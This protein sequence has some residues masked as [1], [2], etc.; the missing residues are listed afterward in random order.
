MSEAERQLIGGRNK[1]VRHPEAADKAPVKS[2]SRPSSGVAAANPDRVT[3]QSTGHWD[4]LCQALI[5]SSQQSTTLVRPSPSS[6]VAD[7]TSAM[8]GPRCA[9]LADAAT[10]PP[11]CVIAK[12]VT[13]RI[14]N[15][16]LMAV[17]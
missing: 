3:P 8:S 15:N 6:A 14:R 17:R 16:N 13:S 7:G 1:P 9:T 5:S 12:T 10:A 4:I 11:L 2:R